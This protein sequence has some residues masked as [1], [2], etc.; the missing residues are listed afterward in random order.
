[1]AAVSRPAGTGEPSLS[2]R[3][4]SGTGT[5]AQQWR[6]WP[7][8]S[9]VPGVSVDGLVPAGS[10]LVVVA[11]HPDDEVL[12]A[13]G[14]L[15]LAARAGREVAVFAVTDGDASHP[16]STRWPRE[17]LIRQRALERA[18]ALGVL[19]IDDGVA[20]RLGFGDGTLS[21]SE[22]ELTRV[23]ARL[24]R[25]NDVVVAPWRYD[26][27]P[28]HEAVAGAVARA[29]PFVGARC[30]QVPI[31]GLHWSSPDDG[32]LPWA[33]AVV[34]ALDEATLS[35][36][37]RAVRCFS[38]QLQGDDS[39]GCA[40]ILPPWAVDR[41]VVDREVYLLDA[42]DDLAASAVEQERGRG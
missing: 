21:R 10:R 37:S 9:S 7:G 40:E 13:G 8:W 19:G 18:A 29:A 2:A 16:N 42:T 32:W 26:G 28:D 22:A 41:L 27:H 15:S 14:L 33:R 36:K 24:L 11:P 5:S 30:L 1:M 35:R 4:I 25:R 3:T 38:S 34:L 6:D 23:L 12:G 17:A 31:W 39:T 20:R